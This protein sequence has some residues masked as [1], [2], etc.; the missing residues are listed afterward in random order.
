MILS[1][2]LPGGPVVR[3][4]PFNAGGAGLILGQGAKILTCLV[5]KKHKTEQYCNQLKTLTLNTNLT[6]NPRLIQRK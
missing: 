5:A 1:R 4:L 3:T 2:D 6:R